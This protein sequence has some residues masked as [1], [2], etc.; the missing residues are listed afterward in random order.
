MKKLVGTSIDKLVIE[1]SIKAIYDTHKIFVY[2]YDNFYIA[3]R[4]RES[5][6][7]CWWYLRIAKS[8]DVCY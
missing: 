3:N 4:N 8:G 6:H 7:V 5:D 1:K 2:M